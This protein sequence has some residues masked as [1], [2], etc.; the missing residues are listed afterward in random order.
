MPPK[1]SRPSTPSSP[2]PAAGG[3][4]RRETPS[5]PK[6]PSYS[7]FG[8]AAGGGP[9]RRP[10]RPV[11]TTLSTGELPVSTVHGSPVATPSPES[12]PSPA[13][14][15]M[16]PPAGVSP[17]SPP[18]RDRTPTSSARKGMKMLQPTYGMP[19][20]GAYL[21]G[22]AAKQRLFKA[23]RELRRT[24]P[25]H[26]AMGGAFAVLAKALGQRMGR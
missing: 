9:P 21:G 8:P 19:R 18:T 26:G 3:R 25:K 23:G 14:G 4:A 15:S 22:F 5:P 12:M 10:R 6:S 24:M 16:L 11:R 2:S 17:D 1:R 20:Q 7:S 13:G